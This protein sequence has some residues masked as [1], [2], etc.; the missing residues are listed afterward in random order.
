MFNYFDDIP[1]AI[2]EV[3]RK[4][5][6]VAVEDMTYSFN[7]KQKIEKRSKIKNIDKKSIKFLEPLKGKSIM[8][9]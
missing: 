2:N 8:P 9:V 6:L 5:K 1:R 3:M 7:V 4:A